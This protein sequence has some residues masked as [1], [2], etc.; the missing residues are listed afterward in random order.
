MSLN[1]DDIPEKLPPHP[2]ED[3][4][5]KSERELA[6]TLQQLSKKTQRSL[7][8]R[9]PHSRVDAAV[10]LAQLAQ[11]AAAGQK[12]MVAAINDQMAVMREQGEA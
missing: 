6:V 4:L 10:G 12:A 8:S 7:L 11:T 5:H 1:P 3:R 9:D 2:E